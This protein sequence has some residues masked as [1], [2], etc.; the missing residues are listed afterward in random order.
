M[1]KTLRNVSIV[2]SA[3]SL[4]FVLATIS[5]LIFSLSQHIFG[6]YSYESDVLII[7]SLL[8]LISTSIPFVLSAL[9]S[10]LM[11]AEYGG[12]MK[13]QFIRLFVILVSSPFLTLLIIIPFILVVVFSFVYGEIAGFLSNYLD[14]WIKVDKNQLTNWVS[15]FILGEC[16]Y[17]A[18]RYSLFDWFLSSKETSSINLAEKQYRVVYDNIKTEG[19]KRTADLV[20]SGIRISSINLIAVLFWSYLMLSNI[21]SVSAEM[22]FSPT[23]IVALFFGLIPLLLFQLY[24]IHKKSSRK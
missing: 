8:L 18:Y 21:S 19:E 15:F 7:I 20:K 22:I 10:N 13:I 6:F 16:V 2:L 5:F 23:M 17:Y 4:I 3:L 9:A 14:Y 12:K 1:E 11:I 24:K